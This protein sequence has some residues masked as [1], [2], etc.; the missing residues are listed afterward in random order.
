MISLIRA[1]AA[2]VNSW[3]LKLERRAS[4]FGWMI[5]TIQDLDGTS[6]AFDGNTSRRHL[7]AYLHET[8]K[9]LTSLESISM[10]M[11]IS[12]ELMPEL[13]RR[14]KINV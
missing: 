6:Q 12:L 9:D 11:F 14:L 2:G 5:G 7:S 10:C 1:I 13:I 4:I 3:P 8:R